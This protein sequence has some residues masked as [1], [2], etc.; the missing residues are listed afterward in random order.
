VARLS[1]R[2]DGSLWPFVPQFTQRDKDA[3][4]LQKDFPLVWGLCMYLGDIGRELEY[5]E[6]DLTS[7]CGESGTCNPDGTTSCD[8]PCIPSRP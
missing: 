2:A 8:Y 5:L 6:P 3:D 1:G 7:N 4:E